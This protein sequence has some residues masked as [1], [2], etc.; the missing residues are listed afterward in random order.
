MV[1]IAGFIGGAVSFCARA[2][3]PLGISAAVIVIASVAALS[4]GIMEN[5]H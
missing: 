3:I 5:V 1:M 2:W 4:L